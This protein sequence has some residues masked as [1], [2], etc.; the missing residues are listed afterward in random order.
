VQLIQRDPK[1][2][3]LDGQD[4]VKLKTALADPAGRLRHIEEVLR[5]LS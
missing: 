2:Y 4:K 5:R 1:H 3:A